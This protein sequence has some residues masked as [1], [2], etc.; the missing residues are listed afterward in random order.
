MTNHLIPRTAALTLCLA[1]ATVR[2]QTA[3]LVVAGGEGWTTTVAAK[4]QTAATTVLPITDCPD[5]PQIALRLE[6]GAQALERNV[7]PYL[8]ALRGAFGLLEVPDVGRLE[9]HLRHGH[10]C[11]TSFYAVPALRLK[12]E[13]NHDSARVPMIVNDDVE[14][15]WVILFGDPGPITFEIFNEHGTLVHTEVAGENDF[16]SDWKMLVHPI[17]QRIPIGTLVI[18]EGDKTRPAVPVDPET[19]YGFVIIAARD[20]SSNHVRAWE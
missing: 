11:G 12:L 20:G 13:K 15:T 4:N 14:Q 17:E 1:A 9:T 10:P 6:P 7:V 3:Q 19:Y 8:C 16:I 18:T 2:A 5:G